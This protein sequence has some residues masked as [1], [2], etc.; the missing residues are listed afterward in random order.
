[1]HHGFALESTMPS[2]QLMRLC[3]PECFCWK[4][5]IFVQNTDFIWCSC[6]C[7]HCTRWTNEISAS[8]LPNKCGFCRSKPIWNTNYFWPVTCSQ[9]CKYSIVA[10]CNTIYVRA[11]KH[12]AKNFDV[13][14]KLGDW[15]GYKNK[16]EIGL[17][18]QIQKSE[19]FD[20]SWKEL[21]DWCTILQIALFYG[22]CWVVFTFQCCFNV[23]I[24]EYSIR[25]LK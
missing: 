9:V 7:L 3:A 25:N 16:T 2:L 12:L 19:K 8:L 10:E 13:I 15:R 24:Y 17:M 6:V 20:K 22:L 18:A 1:M 5:N 23:K 21:G 4:W 11:Y 14:N